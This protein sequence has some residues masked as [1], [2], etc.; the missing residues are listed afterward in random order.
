MCNGNLKECFNIHLP[1]MKIY[2]HI[3]VAVGLEAFAV[4]EAVAAKQ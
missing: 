1:M 4:M 3:H 2:I